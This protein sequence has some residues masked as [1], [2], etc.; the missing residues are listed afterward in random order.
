MLPTRKKKESRE[1]AVQGTSC[2]WNCCTTFELLD[3]EL[4]IASA[5]LKSK[6]Y[7]Y[8]ATGKAGQGWIGYWEW[9]V[10]HTQGA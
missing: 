5:R 1:P 3:R 10:R 2:L 7:L 8:T 4:D 9:E 6:T